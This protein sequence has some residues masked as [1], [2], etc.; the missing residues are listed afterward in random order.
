MAEK[1]EKRKKFQIKDGVE[2]SGKRLKRGGNKWEN[3]FKIAEK[4]VDIFFICWARK[5]SKKSR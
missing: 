4:K 2:K 1:V 3:F 5:N